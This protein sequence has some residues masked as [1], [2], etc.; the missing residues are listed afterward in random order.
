M[1]DG[2]RAK[3]RNESIIAPEQICNRSV[4]VLFLS[5]ETVCYG[6]R[7]EQLSVT[8]TIVAVYFCIAV[9]F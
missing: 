5:D 6:G 7:L 3:H 8:G 4:R 1:S 2:R 9:Y